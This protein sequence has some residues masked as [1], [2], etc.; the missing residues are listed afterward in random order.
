ML[1]R[2]GI[3]II[4]AHFKIHSCLTQV[5]KNILFI[6][7]NYTI[8]KC[9][10]DA[11]LQFCLCSMDCISAAFQIGLQDYTWKNT[12]NKCRQ[13]L[14][15]SP[16][17]FN[18]ANKMQ[19]QGNYTCNFTHEP[20]D[21]IGLRV[22]LILHRIQL[23]AQQQEVKTLYSLNLVGKKRHKNKGRRGG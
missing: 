13:P 19:G 3:N 5:Q 21:L 23:Q 6:C 15:C 10:A 4:L 11:D 8:I 2:V 9:K 17:N 7:Y 1:H 16:T 18:M 20:T 12:T 22:C 14:L